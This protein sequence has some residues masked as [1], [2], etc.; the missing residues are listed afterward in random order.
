MYSWQ[1]L[2][3]QLIAQQWW[4]RRCCY[5]VVFVTVLSLFLSMFG[6]NSAHIRSTGLIAFKDDNST[7][8]LLGR[9][10]S[11]STGWIAYFEEHNQLQSD[12]EASDTMMRHTLYE[13]AR[14][15]VLRLQ[16]QFCRDLAR[17]LAHVVLVLVPVP[18]CCLD[19]AQLPVRSYLPRHRWL[20]RCRSKDYVTPATNS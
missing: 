15:L 5:A 7:T 11:P 20:H 17:K 14:R 10:V 3:K 9:H 2:Q 1:K 12:S 13:A 6:T 4:V 16:M 19:D 8:S 18:S